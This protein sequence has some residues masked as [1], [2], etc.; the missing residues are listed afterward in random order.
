MG[1]RV[2]AEA[3]K[4]QLAVTGDEDRLQLEWHQALLRAKCRRPLA[5]VLASRV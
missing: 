1:I 5:A 2:D 4:R 3:L